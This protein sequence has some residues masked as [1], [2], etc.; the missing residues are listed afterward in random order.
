MFD[1]SLVIALAAGETWAVRRA[2]WG[3]PP[4]RALGLWTIAVVCLVI[5]LG[6]H[7]AATAAPSAVTAIALVLS[8]WTSFTLWWLWLVRA[9]APRFG[10]GPDDEG[11]GGGGGGPDDGGPDNG[12]QGPPRGGD[13][14][15]V[16]WEAFE[17]D[18]AD[19][20]EQARRAE[21]LG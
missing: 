12:G 18:F 17:R 10:D 14:H 15:D 13:Q 6:F 8:G 4:A 1:V 21:T 3:P 7:T 11:G 5:Q 20:A 19:Y 9:P 16:D 2:L